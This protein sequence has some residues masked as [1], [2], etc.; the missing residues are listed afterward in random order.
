MAKDRR[1]AFLTP[2]FYGDFERC[3]FLCESLSKFVVDDF[4]HYLVVDRSD[5]S[6][7]RDLESPTTRVI[8][9]EDIL[10]SWIIK[11]RIPLPKKGRNV[12]LSL[13]SRPVRGWHV[14]QMAKLT[15]CA[16]LDH[17]LVVMV[18]SDV[19]LTRRFEVAEVTGGGPPPLYCKPAVI[20]EALPRHVAWQQTANRVLG[21]TAPE[22]PSPDFITPYN[23]W[24]PDVVRA[25]RQ[26]IESVAGTDWMLVVARNWEFCEP[27]VYG[28]F[29]RVEG[30]EASGHV[31]T[32][33]PLCYSYWPHKRISNAE[34]ADY[35]AEM[36]DH[37]YAVNIQS[38]SEMPLDSY[39]HLVRGEAPRAKAS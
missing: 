19:F 25:M 23:F 37:C 1:L 32:D 9:K 18:D 13:K 14:Q 20:T 12:R 5:V 30:P 11:V 3:A 8:A 6:L 24:R 17:E 33:K 15:T 35:L 29:V 16:E 21:L 7:F 34:M 26:R 28:T 10:P 31:L 4:I 27:V 38:K 2:S 22:F 36:P 39:A